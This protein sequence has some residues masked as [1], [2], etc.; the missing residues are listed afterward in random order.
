MADTGKMCH[1]APY[2]TPA[3]LPPPQFCP[4]M[5]IL[6]FQ[7]ATRTARHPDLHSLCSASDAQTLASVIPQSTLKY[8]ST[9]HL[10]WASLSVH[11]AGLPPG[12]T[13]SSYP[14]SLL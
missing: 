3:R 8:N 13:S 4:L 10:Y 7:P 12:N 2:Q 14:I 6:T 9:H 5:G 11:W 1:Q